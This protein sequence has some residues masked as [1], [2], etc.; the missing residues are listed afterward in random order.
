MGVEFITYKKQKYP[1]KVGYYVLKML[2]AETGKGIE[3][4]SKDLSLYEPMLYYSLVKGAKIAGTELGLKR[5][6]MEDVLE[7]V[8]YD[9]INAIPKFFVKADDVPGEVKKKK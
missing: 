2:K 4:T 6:D 3:D 1:I 5:E 8:L 7:E 9:F